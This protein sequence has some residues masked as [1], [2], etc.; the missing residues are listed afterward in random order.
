MIT[1]YFTENGVVLNG[2]F[3]ENPKNL[4]EEMYE[5]RLRIERTKICKIK[6]QT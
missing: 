2:M 1:D 3:Y 6:S 5:C 4:Q